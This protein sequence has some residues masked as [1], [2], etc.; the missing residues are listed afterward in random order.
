MKQLN[1]TEQFAQL[2]DETLYPELSD[3]LKAALLEK[4]IA[5]TRSKDSSVA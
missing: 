3:A 4:L 1:T 2:H 5:V